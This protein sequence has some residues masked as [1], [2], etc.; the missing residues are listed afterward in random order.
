MSLKANSV[1]DTVLETLNP[2]PGCQ[3]GAPIWAI[4]E[5]RSDSEMT[6]GGATEP[7][8]MNSWLDLVVEPFELR[9]VF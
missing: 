8:V 9:P 3:R 1:Y 4:S 5:R 2:F 6:G 7:S